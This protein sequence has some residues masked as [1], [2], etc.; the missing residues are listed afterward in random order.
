MHRPMPSTVVLGTAILA[1]TGLLALLVAEAVGA[2]DFVRLAWVGVAMAIV[3]GGGVLVGLRLRHVEAVLLSPTSAWGRAPTAMAAPESPD[4]WLALL[5]RV[6]SALS[7]EQ[8]MA[9]ALRYACEAMDQWLG[10]HACGVFLDEEVTASLQLPALVHAGTLT[11][12]DVEMVRQLTAEPP[13]LKEDALVLILPLSDDRRRYGCFFAVCA[14]LIQA[15]HL[16]RKLA[17]LLARHLAWSIGNGMRLQ[18]GRR[19]ALIEER[20]ALAREL[21]DSLAQSLAFMKIQVSLLQTQAS[22]A[23]SQQALR[24]T[25]AELRVGLNSAY[26]KLREL[27]TTFRAQSHL[28]GL[29]ASLEEALDEYGARSNVTMTLDYRLGELQLAVNEEFHIVQIVR[30]ALSNIVRHS[31]AVHAT[32]ALR[33]RADSLVEVV[34]EDDGVGFDLPEDSHLHHGMAIMRERAASL[35]G[36]LD[37]A[38]RAGGGCRVSACFRPTG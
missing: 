16:D 19:L 9:P 32:V 20:A 10:A 17:A 11:L 27:I 25:A 26:R 28:H 6:V 2:I 13:S 5:D 38:L 12:D 34:I 14:D 8:L 37:I 29:A 23:D 1:E 4:R 31:G 7:G 30:E 18:D 36:T 15:K 33:A 24:D 35:G 21:H 3:S 22:R